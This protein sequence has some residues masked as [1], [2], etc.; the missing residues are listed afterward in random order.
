MDQEEDEGKKQNM[1]LMVKVS[2]FADFAREQALKNGDL[3]IANIKDTDIVGKL[4]KTPEQMDAMSKF[5][6]D[7][8]DIK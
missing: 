8:T 4:I 6:N 7:E 1:K 5:I 2:Q 3:G